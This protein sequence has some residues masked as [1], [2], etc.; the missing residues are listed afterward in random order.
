MQCPGSI[1]RSPAWD[2]LPPPA[3]RPSIPSRKAAGSC[4][5]R[6]DCLNARL[7]L[8]FAARP[9]QTRQQRPG[10]RPRRLKVLDSFVKDLTTESAGEHR[11]FRGG[12]YETRPY[13]IFP[14]RS[15]EPSTPRTPSPAP[16]PQPGPALLPTVVRRFVLRSAAPP[17]R[18]RPSGSPEPPPRDSLK[19]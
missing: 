19:D 4:R 7:Q 8:G 11:G 17:I 6:R 1:A 18:Q 12:V 9:E 3:G 5:P 13:H 2:R 10:L 16:Q 15:A 14:S